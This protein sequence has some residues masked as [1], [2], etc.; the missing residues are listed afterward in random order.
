MPKV[1]TGF[2][3]PLASLGLDDWNASWDPD[4]DELD[5]LWDCDEDDADEAW[6]AREERDC[7]RRWSRYQ[8]QVELRA[9]ESIP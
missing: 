2:L 4:V 5:R 3:H 9:E 1:R 7:E 6:R 8:L